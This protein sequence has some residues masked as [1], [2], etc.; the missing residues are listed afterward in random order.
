MGDQRR[1]KRSGYKQWLYDSALSK[2]KV[3]KWR[4]QKKNTR[5]KPIKADEDGNDTTWIDGKLE[6]EESSCIRVPHV[7][8]CSASSL[9]QECVDVDDP[10]R[11]ALASDCLSG[12]CC[13]EFDDNTDEATGLSSYSGSCRL[14]LPV[15]SKAYNLFSPFS[16]HAMIHCN[17]N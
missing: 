15:S 6:F 9:L 11:T 12:D 5:S 14:S 2:P 1:G 10:D 17:T 7:D 4:E 3:T 16:V 8:E 13:A